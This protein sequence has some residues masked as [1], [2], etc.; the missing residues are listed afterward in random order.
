MKNNFKYAT[1]SVFGF[2][3]LGLGISLQIKAAIGQSM[4]NAFALT[5]SDTVN[6]KVG[7]VLNILN[8][9]FFISYLLTRCTKFNY[10]DI[11]QVVATIANGYII[12][13]FVYYVLSNLIVEAYIYKIIIFLIGLLLSS[14][15][16]GAILAIGIVKFPLES[17]CLTICDI[18]NK[19]LST[20]RRIFDM[21]FLLTTLCIT[22]INGSTLHI[23]EATII[24]FFL[25]SSLL[26]I[27]YTFFKKLLKSNK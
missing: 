7:T 19:K 17:L 5:L 11:I 22:F 10:T 16:L 9:L 18:F 6:L 1:Y 2:V 26:G 20:I 4:L 25:L 15:S 12:N 24:S 14:T 13:F 21:I 23:R 3:F 27:S 8:L